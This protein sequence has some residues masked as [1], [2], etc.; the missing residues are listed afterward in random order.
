MKQQKKK[1]IVEGYLVDKFGN[2]ISNNFTESVMAVSFDEAENRVKFRI[3]TKK[4]KLSPNAYVK[5]MQSDEQ[6]TYEWF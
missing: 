4:L 6:D 5:L 1:Y 3:K 2:R